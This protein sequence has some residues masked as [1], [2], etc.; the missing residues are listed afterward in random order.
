[1]LVSVMFVGKY[2]STSFTRVPFCRLFRGPRCLIPLLYDLQAHGNVQKLLIAISIPR[3]EL[4]VLGDLPAAFIK[5]LPLTLDCNQV[6][7]HGETSTVDIG[8]PVPCTSFSINKV[9]QMTIFKEVPQQ[10][11][12]PVR[13]DLAGVDH[14]TLKGPEPDSFVCDRA[15]EEHTKMCHFTEFRPSEAETFW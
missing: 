11:I 14:F 12:I 6:L 9:A 10:G 8:H 13:P 2:F 1:M 5:D 15:T 3:K 7:L 4:W